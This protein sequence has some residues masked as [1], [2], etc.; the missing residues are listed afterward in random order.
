MY[1]LEKGKN[2]YHDLYFNALFYIVDKKNSSS[3]H[4]IEVAGSFYSS[5]QTP[6]CYCVF[7]IYSVNPGICRHTQC[8]KQVGIF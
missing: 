4:R 8:P 6:C 1:F 7:Q 5:L 3:H 2:I